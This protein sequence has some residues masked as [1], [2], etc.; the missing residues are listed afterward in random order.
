MNTKG[1]LHNN[2]TKTL[3]RLKN[4]I[5]SIYFDKFKAK[6]ETDKICGDL[7]N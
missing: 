2:R 3:H 6:P 7:K 1:H 4:S 5:D